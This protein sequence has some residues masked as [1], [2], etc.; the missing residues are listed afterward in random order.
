MSSLCYSAEIFGRRTF[1]VVRENAPFIDQMF[2]HFKAFNI[3]DV[4]YAY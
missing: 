4:W 3:K 1:F 2:S